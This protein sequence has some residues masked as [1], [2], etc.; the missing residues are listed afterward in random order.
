MK[1]RALSLAVVFMGSLGSACNSSTTPP[2]QPATAGMTTGISGSPATAGKPAANG[3][4]PAAGMSGG[5]MTCGTATCMPPQAIPGFMV[6]PM[7]CCL[8]AA[9]SKCGFVVKGTCTPP[10]PDAPKCPMTA[11]SQAKPCCVM[12]SNIC[13]IDATA[14]GMGCLD[15]TP[16]AK[17]MCDGTMMGS[18]GSGGA[19]AAG[20]GAGMS[21][22][23]G[24]GAGGMAAAAGASGSAA[25]SGG[26]KAGAGGSSAGGAGAAGH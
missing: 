16:G 23:A 2:A 20:G 9:T 25:G 26:A 5:S 13:G 22:A 17:T 15:I 14:F 24:S 8:D 1:F 12:A 7:S 6:T 18:P 19:P 11:F 3:G 21:A 10:A 4:A